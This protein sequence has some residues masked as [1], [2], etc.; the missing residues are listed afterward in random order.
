[1]VI[2]YGPCASIASNA[3]STARTPAALG[4]GDGAWRGVSAPAEAEPGEGALGPEPAGPGDV[5]AAGEA[6]EQA[7]SAAI[8]TAAARARDIRRHAVISAWKCSGEEWLGT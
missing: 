6:S 5:T 4:V 2:R 8:A 3:L 7:V 1:M